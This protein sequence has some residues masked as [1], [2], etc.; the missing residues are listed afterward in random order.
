VESGTYYLVFTTDFYNNLAELTTNNNG[1]TV[2]ITVTI[3]PAD[4]APLALQVPSILNGAP[5]PK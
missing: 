3:T 2:P 5:D 4:L 1:I